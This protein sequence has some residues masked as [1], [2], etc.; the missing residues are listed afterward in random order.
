MPALNIYRTLNKTMQPYAPRNVP[1]VYHIQNK[2]YYFLNSWG[3]FLHP[4]LGEAKQ[5]RD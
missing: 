3:F 5:S 2:F 1:T 4:R